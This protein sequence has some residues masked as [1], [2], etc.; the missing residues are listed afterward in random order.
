VGKTQKLVYANAVYTTANSKLPEV[1]PENPTF[2]TKPK[3]ISVRPK[4]ERVVHKNKPVLPKGLE[5]PANFVIPNQSLTFP[6]ETPTSVGYSINITDILPPKANQAKA[7]PKLKP[8][9]RVLAEDAV[10]KKQPK[11]MAPQ[12]A[13]MAPVNSFFQFQENAEDITAVIPITIIGSNQQPLTID[14]NNAQFFSQALPQLVPFQTLAPAQDTP[15]S[16]KL[17]EG[18]ENA[19]VGGMDRVVMD[20]VQDESAARAAGNSVGEIHHGLTKSKIFLNKSS[21]S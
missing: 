21:L 10:P 20:G 6:V 12:P 13:K 19:P 11:M 7:A 15:K 9:P 4:R 16:D 18:T 3:P 17:T 2:Q 8:A 14:P 1:K 5:T